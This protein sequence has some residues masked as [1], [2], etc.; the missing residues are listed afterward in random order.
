[1]AEAPDG[2]SRSGMGQSRDE[3]YALRGMTSALCQ[4]EAQFS[5]RICLYLDLLRRGR[6]SRRRAVYTAARGICALH[7][8][9]F[10]ISL[11]YCPVEFLSYQMKQLM[12][13]YEPITSFTGE[14]SS[15]CHALP[16]LSIRVKSTQY[17]KYLKIKSVDLLYQ[18]R[19]REMGPET[20]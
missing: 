3:D 7:V 2:K 6:R 8:S 10:S 19:P 15:F 18:S 17:P 12:F 1:V 13:C 4:F 14:Q 20:L 11:H 9:P 16:G 5:V